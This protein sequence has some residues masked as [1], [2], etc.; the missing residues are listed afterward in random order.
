MPF[1][2]AGDPCATS[3]ERLLPGLSHLG[4]PLIE[5]GIPF[6]DP[7]ADGPVI[8]EAMHSALGR[9]CTLR[10]A[11]ESVRSV[12]DRV[13]CP[14]AAMVSASIVE[15]VGAAA[16]CRDAAAAGFDAI[17]VPDIDLDVAPTLRDTCGQEGIGLTL[18]VA[19][20][21]GEERVARI[22]TL[23]T[24][25]VYAVARV[26]IT[27][28]RSDAPTVAPLVARIRRYT[29]LPVAAGFGISTREHV[30]AVLE[31][32]DGAIVGSALVRCMRDAE[33]S[34]R[35][36]EDEAVALVGRLIGR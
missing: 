23:C 24:G 4:V 16:F 27:G 29:D 18:L 10:S 3:L 36:P 33:T 7:I 1:V 2:V 22:A 34:G 35:R 26:G 8:A 20:T 19:P 11:F 13:S 28:E 31:S 30:R 12:R 17:I 5:V 32:A 25:F 21:S 14:L 9:G 6:S 15:R